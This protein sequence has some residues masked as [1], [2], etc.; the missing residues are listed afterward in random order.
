MSLATHTHTHPS[1]PGFID[2]LSVLGTMS[3]GSFSLV[4]NFQNGSV[5]A[6]RLSSLVM[7]LF[8]AIS[9]VAI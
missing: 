8:S 7:V 5:T 3:R 9:L 1:F 4:S 6:G 2:H